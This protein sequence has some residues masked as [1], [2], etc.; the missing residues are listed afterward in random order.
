VYTTWGR[1]EYYNKI[2]DKSYSFEWTFILVEKWTDAKGD[3][4]Y[5]AFNQYRNGK[6]Y[7]L[8]KTSK[9]GTVFEYVEGAGFPKVSELDPKSNS[10]R[11]YYRQ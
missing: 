5:K 7:F 9:G 1:G 3:I 4:W 11:V 2:S 8:I 10:Y 6:E